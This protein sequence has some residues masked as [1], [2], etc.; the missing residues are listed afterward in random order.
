MKVF[1]TSLVSILSWSLSLA[2]SV[3]YPN[4]LAEISIYT[5]D[6][7]YIVFPSLFSQQWH[8]HTE[9]EIHDGT[10]IP[11]VDSLINTLTIALFWEQ[12][13]HSLALT[14]TRRTNTDLHTT[15]DILWSHLRFKHDMEW[16]EY[17]ETLA[18]THK[19]MFNT[20]VK[21]QYS[22]HIPQSEKYTIQIHPIN[23]EKTNI[24]ISSPVR[25]I[26]KPLFVFTDPI[27]DLQIQ[28]ISLR[29]DIS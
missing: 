22:L 23:W 8:I 19:M 27:L 18:G 20:Q 5:W 15:I 14:N 3:E 28:W 11:N 7:Q 16:W 9:T 13:A 17:P 1:I 24:S 6:E 21:D 26:E 12:S 29:N 4:H 25:N 2:S 10:E